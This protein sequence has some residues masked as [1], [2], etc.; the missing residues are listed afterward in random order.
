M[1]ILEAKLN[2]N[3]ISIH[4]IRIFVVKMCKNGLRILEAKFSC[5]G[6]QTFSAGMDMCTVCD[7]G[8]VRDPPHVEVLSD[9][10]LGGRGGPLG[11]GGHGGV[12]DV[13][14][15]IQCDEG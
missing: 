2:E 14:G 11:M 13:E 12:G 3:R 1:V 15:R 9:P 10:T 8:W 5:G 6:H 7:P 4:K